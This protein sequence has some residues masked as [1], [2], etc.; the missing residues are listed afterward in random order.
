MAVVAVV[1]SG[2]YD[3]DG[4]VVLVWGNSMAYVIMI[5]FMLVLF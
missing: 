3:R 5:M 1:G 2:S 4:E